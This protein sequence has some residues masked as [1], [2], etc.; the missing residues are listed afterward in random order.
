MLFT[1]SPVNTDASD[2]FTQKMVGAV[3]KPGLAFA[4]AGA[5]FNIDT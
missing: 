1:G 5:P 2:S 3:S 4:S